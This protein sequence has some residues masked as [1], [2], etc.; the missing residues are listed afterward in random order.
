MVNTLY[1]ILKLVHILGAMVWLGGIVALVVLN[2]RLG[3][4]GNPMMMAALGRQSEFFG[5]N[6][7]GPAMLVTLLAGLFTAG[8]AQLPFTT[9]WIVWGLVGFVASILIGVI[10]V[11]R[12]AG[13]LAAIA[14]EGTPDDPRLAAARGRL[15]ALNAVNL[16]L[17]VSVVAAMVIKPALS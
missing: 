5:R 13:S 3:R 10:A 15:V 2:A 12:A 4:E 16:L 9:L 8:V 14:R 6:V 7:L 17:L 11:H 1:L